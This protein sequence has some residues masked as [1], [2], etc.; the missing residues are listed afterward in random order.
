MSQGRRGLP[1]FDGCLGVLGRGRKSFGKD[2]MM[3]CYQ[4]K[5]IDR[6]VTEATPWS[7]MNFV[8]STYDEPEHAMGKDRWWTNIW[9]GEIILLDCEWDGRRDREVTAFVL[10]ENASKHRW[11]V[12]IGNAI[13]FDLDMSVTHFA[14]WYYNQNLLDPSRLTRAAVRRLP[15]LSRIQGDVHQSIGL[16][17]KAWSASGI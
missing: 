4:N 8:W 9:A 3:N 17:H 7:F 16:T 12:E 11:W 14:F 2:E 6:P 5:V 15:I 13:A 10:V 1:A